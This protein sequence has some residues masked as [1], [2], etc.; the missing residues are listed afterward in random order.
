MKSIICTVS[1]VL[2][3]VVKGFEFWMKYGILP[4]K[5]FK[6]FG[7][8]DLDDKCIV[9]YLRFYREICFIT[10]RQIIFNIIKHLDKLAV[11]EAFFNIKLFKIWIFM[12][13]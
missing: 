9:D 8:M 13:L 2:E 10:C 5:G 3:D 4:S 7:E 1:A 6:D 12:Y 11:G